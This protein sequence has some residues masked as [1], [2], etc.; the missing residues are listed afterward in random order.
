[1]TLNKEHFCNLV[2]R[3]YRVSVFFFQRSQSGGTQYL[4]TGA[5]GGTRIPTSTAQGKQLLIAHQLRFIAV[6]IQ[7]NRLIRKPMGREE[8]VHISEV[9][10]F[11]GLN[12]SC[13]RKRKGVII[14]GVSSF[15][16]CP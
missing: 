3:I 2:P 9:S 10:L 15:Q 14:R 1:M 6:Y 12:C 16:G 4:I 5:S 8:S 11:Q 13:F 7:W